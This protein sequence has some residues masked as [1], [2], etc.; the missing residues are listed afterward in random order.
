MPWS[1]HYDAFVSYSHKDNDVVKPLVELLSLNEHQVFWDQQ[2]KAGDRW[3]QVIRS[4]VKQSSVFVL[5]WCCDTH[6]SQY[7][8]KEIALAVHLKK[9]IVPV[10]LCAAAMPLPLSEWQWIDLGQRV[11]HQCADVDHNQARN[12]LASSDEPKAASST[13]KRWAWLSFASA[14]LLLIFIFG[15]V[16]PRRSKTGANGYAA[17]AQVLESRYWPIPKGAVRLKNG[18]ALVKPPERDENGSI[19]LLNKHGDVVDRYTIASGS[20]P[21]VLPAFRE[22]EMPW[23]YAYRRILYVVGLFAVMVALFTWRIVSRRDRANQ[24]L[25][26]TMDYLRPLAQEN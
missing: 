5:F 7:V 16:L 17:H 19:V 23:W 13:W 20:A 8:A 24:T 15:I 4:A 9:K 12:S 22:V 1:K 11:H 2:L 18:Y 21:L 14:L 3:D 25:S 10:K 6:G 26:I